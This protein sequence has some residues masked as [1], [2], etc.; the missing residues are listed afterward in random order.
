MVFW[1]FAFNLDELRSDTRSLAIRIDDWFV[2]SPL[3]D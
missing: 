2:I 1:Q 3:N